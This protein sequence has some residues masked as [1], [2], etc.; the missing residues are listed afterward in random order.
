MQTVLTIKFISNLKITVDYCEDKV[1]FLG[2]VIKNLGT[3]S[4]PLYFRLKTVCHTMKGS[5]DKAEEVKHISPYS[6]HPH[7]IKSVFRTH[8][9]K[10]NPEPGLNLKDLSP[11]FTSQTFRNKCC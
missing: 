11:I 3:L 2:W 5:M 1:H 6:P 7:V 9:L 4:I 8:I 10:L